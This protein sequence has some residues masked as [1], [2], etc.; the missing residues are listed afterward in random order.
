MSANSN[1]QA[2]KDDLYM[3]EKIMESF[4]QKYVFYIDSRAIGKYRDVVSYITK[5]TQDI[6]SGRIKKPDAGF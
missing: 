2:E 1:W 4:L 3:A 6:D 5:F